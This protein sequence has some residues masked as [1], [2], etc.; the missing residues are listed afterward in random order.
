MCFVL[1]LNAM[2]LK[3][4][5]ARQK[6]RVVLA[7]IF[8]LGAILYLLLDINIVFSLIL[9][10]RSFQRIHLLAS[11]AAI[12]GVTSFKGNFRENVVLM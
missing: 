1:K 8:L 4:I 12:V 2:L 10:E 7:L 3:S 5:S 11:H 9:I 6:P